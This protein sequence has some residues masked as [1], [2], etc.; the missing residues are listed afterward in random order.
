MTVIPGVVTAGLAV[1]ARRAVDGVGSQVLPEVP[2]KNTLIGLREAFLR[3]DSGA[4]TDDTR[5]TPSGPAPLFYRKHCPGRGRCLHTEIAV[6]GAKPMRKLICWVI[7]PSA[8]RGDA[9]D[10]VILEWKP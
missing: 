9:G 1:H 8:S 3:W 5:T 10:L 4:A 7:Y 2:E 6:S